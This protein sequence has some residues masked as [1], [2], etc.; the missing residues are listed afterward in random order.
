MIP[1]AFIKMFLQKLKG[2]NASKIALEFGQGKYT[3][4]FPIYLLFI[5]HLR[6]EY[7]DC[8]IAASFLWCGHCGFL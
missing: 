2:V 1:Q 6:L 8:A 7:R 5:A 3:N 4:S